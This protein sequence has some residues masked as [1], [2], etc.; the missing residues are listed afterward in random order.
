MLTQ[1]EIERLRKAYGSDFYV[2]LMKA[3]ADLQVAIEDLDRVMQEAYD[4]IE[5][6]DV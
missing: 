5:E 6:V 1:Q 3:R 2:A 4:L